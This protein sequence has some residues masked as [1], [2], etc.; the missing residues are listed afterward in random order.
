[1]V[2]RGNNEIR[3][4]IVR[5]GTPQVKI[6]KIVVGSTQIHQTVYNI[7]LHSSFSD[8]EQIG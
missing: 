3:L 6:G 2:G 5:F 1:M 7:D 8:E 4:S